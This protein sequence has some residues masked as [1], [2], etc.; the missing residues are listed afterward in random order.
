MKNNTVDIHS[1]SINGACEISFKFRQIITMTIIS[2]IPHRIN[3]LSIIVL[4]GLKNNKSF[5]NNDVWYATAGILISR[6]N[7][8]GIDQL[9][10]IN[11]MIM[12][13]SEYKR[14][15]AKYKLFHD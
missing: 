15:L 13:S 5:F 8:L 3:K 14:Q 12:N 4:S 7:S 11:D 6:Y 9:I 10:E 2:F 1:E